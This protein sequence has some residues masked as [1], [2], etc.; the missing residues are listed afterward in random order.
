MNARAIFFFKVG[1]GGQHTLVTF[2]NISEGLPNPDMTPQKFMRGCLTPAHVNFFK[3][4]KPVV[5]HPLAS[6]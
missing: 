5:M 4:A 3:I 2:K 1:R 6:I